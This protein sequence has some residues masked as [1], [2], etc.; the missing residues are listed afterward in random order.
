MID[1]KTENLLSL[2][3]AAELLPRRRGGKKA[4]VSCVYRW[5]TSGC[6]GVILESIQC[7]GTRVTS[8]EALARFFKKLTDANPLT[9]SRSSGTRSRAA[10]NAEQALDAAGF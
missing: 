4:H 6:K 2:T 5:T 3:E 10:D 8:R 9:A 7:G 1:P